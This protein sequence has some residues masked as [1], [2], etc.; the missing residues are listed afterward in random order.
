VESDA[1]DMLRVWKAVILRELLIG[2]IM[3]TIVDYMVLCIDNF[4]IF[5]LSEYLF[6]YN[7]IVYF[8]QLLQDIPLL[9]EVRTGDYVQ[10]A[11]PLLAL[12]GNE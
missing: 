2:N 9:A 11:T 4:S 5:D 1:R 8:L 7:L 6:F 10:V 12:T 3:K